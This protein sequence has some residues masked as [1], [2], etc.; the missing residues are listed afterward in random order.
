MANKLREEW[1]DF[2]SKIVQLELEKNKAE[3][4]SRNKNSVIG[5][6]P[7]N[8]NQRQQSNESRNSGL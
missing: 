3:S 2:K 1:K 7:K 6:I 5:S 4:Y 8:K